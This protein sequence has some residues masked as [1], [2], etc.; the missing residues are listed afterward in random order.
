MKWKKYLFIFYFLA[1]KHFSSFVQI[2]SSCEVERMTQ[3]TKEK[4][5][6]ASTAELCQTERER[7]I[8]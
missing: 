4:T 7:E 1:I 2:I 3:M 6:I 5:K 8:K